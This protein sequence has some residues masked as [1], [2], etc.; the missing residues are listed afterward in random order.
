MYKWKIEIILKCGKEVIGYYEGSEINSIDV[1]KLYLTD[2][3]GGITDK[4]KTK[5][6]IIITSEIAA[7]T[8]SADRS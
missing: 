1:A 5:Q 3:F 7:M 2:N 4:N 6:I 8:I